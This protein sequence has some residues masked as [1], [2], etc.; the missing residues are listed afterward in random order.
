MTTKKKKARK[1]GEK[2]EAAPAKK[3]SAKRAKKRKIAKELLDGVKALKK[4]RPKPAPEPVPEPEP[5]ISTLPVGAI[6]RWYDEGFRHGR[7]LKV[8]KK[9]IVV[10]QP[11]GPESMRKARVPIDDVELVDERGDPLNPKE[12][13]P[14]ED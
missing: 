4:R 6:A 14:K 10:I 13:A 2:K 5:D 8:T 9:N 1:R 11:F 12:K 7:I 3:K